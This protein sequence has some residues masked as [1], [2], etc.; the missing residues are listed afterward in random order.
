M[1]ARARKDA[2]HNELVS[3][4]ERLGCTVAQMHAC[5]V[6]GFPDIAV[7]AMG[8]TFLVELKNPN[9]SYGK[10]GLNP[11]QSAFSRDWRGGRVY[12]ASTADDVIELVQQW[13]RQYETC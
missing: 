2:N 6:P 13:R 12:M 1:S 10:R 7:G 9:T 5:G 8:K 11:N 3:L 4:F